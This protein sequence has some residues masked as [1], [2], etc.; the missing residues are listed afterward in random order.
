VIVK[1]V[2]GT[3]KAPIQTLMVTPTMLQHEDALVSVS[4]SLRGLQ[5]TA[6]FGRFLHG[7]AARAR[8]RRLSARTER[9]IP[10]R[11]PRAERGPFR[12]DRAEARRSPRSLRPSRSS[13]ARR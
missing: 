13:I 2:K 11:E 7:E 8:S 1:V 4:G 5:L 10:A 3:V 12:P 6:A 9:H